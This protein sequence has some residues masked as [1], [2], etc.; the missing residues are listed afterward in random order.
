MPTAL[1][2]VDVAVTQEAERRARP[3][4]CRDFRL[5]WGGQ[6]ISF[7]GNAASAVALGWRVTELTGS[8]GLRRVREVD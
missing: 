3:F 7:T 2:R 4:S 8:A 5:L 6:A 1:P